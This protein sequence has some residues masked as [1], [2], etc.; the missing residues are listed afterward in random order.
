M[1]TTKTQTL[2]FKHEIDL[3]LVNIL[4]ALLV[5]VIFFIPDSPVRILLGLPFILLFPGYM[6]ICALF[7]RKVDLDIV[8]RLALG[9]GVSVAVTSL[10]GLAL[11]YTSFGIRLYSVAYSLFLFIL[12]MSAVA[13][14]RRSTITPTDVFAPLA[15]S[16]MSG[17][18]EFSGLKTVFTLFRDD[19]RLIKLTATIAF[20]LIALAAIIIKNT[21][22]TGYETSIYKA[23]P[24]LAWIF[25]FF[26]IICGICIVVYNVYTKEHEKNNRWVLGLFL[27]LLSDVILLSLPILRGYAFWGRGD[28]FTH[29]NTVLNIISS[30]QIKT[31]NYYP[32]AHIYVTEC[33]YIFGIS[34]ELLF[35]YIPLLF[36]I[37]FV[38]YMYLFAKS[39]L[40][41]KGQV[42]I[43]TVAS[44]TFLH[45]FYIYFTP[46]GLSNLMLPLVFFVFFKSYEQASH[47]KIEFRMLLI[48]M[49]FL[50]GAF[51]PVPAIALLMLFIFLELFSR[52]LIDKSIKI[53]RLNAT[54]SLILAVWIFTWI[55]SFYVWDATIENLHM[56]MVEGGP[57]AFS[58]LEDKIAYASLYGYSPLVIFLK[59]YSGIIVY[60]ILAFIA[61]FIIMKERR[62]N[63]IFRN[64]ISLSALVVIYS[65]IILLFLAANL[66]FGPLRM[67]FYVIIIC[68]VLVGFVMN[69][70]LR[71]AKHASNRNFAKLTIAFV[72]VI[73]VFSS[74]NGIFRLYP[75]P[76][77]LRYNDQLSHTE[78]EGLDWFHNNKNTSTS[79]LLISLEGLRGLTGIGKKPP[80]HFNY[81][82]H[83][84]LGE[85]YTRASYMTLNKLDRLIY[86]DVFPE[87][88]D[89]RW[90]PDDFEKLEYDTSVDKIYTNRG[91][92]VRWVHALSG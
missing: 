43:A 27:I 22:Y 14:Y 11:N 64:I 9:T 60:F 21:E 38:I 78:I 73:L 44:T 55:S 84:M 6:L 19:N 24:I 69:R 53:S 32:I 72:I 70:I 48:I 13:M 33:Y 90:S 65:L 12:L 37:L 54:L 82:N 5:A 35:K 15:S 92:D 17:W 61:F 16:N 63:E 71:E 68:T 59:Y 67:I 58:H 56:L 28:P 7:P 26:G 83:T 1:N 91:F 40:P 66:P 36:G 41:E 34:V 79:V 39:V 85:S 4:S 80:Y 46:N 52:I 47:L 62:A 20:I 89:C 45:G 10:I 76:Y 42:I 29:I 31:Q 25:L 3:V 88:A 86:V 49:I 18:Y 57:T 51:H 77:V 8:E 75:S 74:I 87:L 30:S 2:N 81:T 50:Y 23:I